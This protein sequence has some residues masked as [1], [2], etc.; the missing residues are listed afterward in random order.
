[1]IF[2]LISRLT[3]FTVGLLAI[4]LPAHG[5]DGGKINVRFVSFPKCADPKDME[6]VVGTEGK[7]MLVELPT[8]SISKTYTIDRPES[9]R[10]GKTDKNEEGKPI[11]NT[12]GQAP[13]IAP[14]EQLV[15]VL[16]KGATDED[17]L[18][19]VPMDGSL[20]GF[21]EASYL[22]YNFTSVKIAAKLGDKAFPVTAMSHEIVKPAPS[23]VKNG[24][25][26]IHVHFATPEKGEWELFHT[27]SWPYV[28]KS[29]TMVFFY[30]DPN[31]PNVLIHGITDYLP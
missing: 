28:K 11:F 26:L 5:Q 6:L 13:M 7:T 1:M 17:G 12:Y 23:E 20:E 9:W 30:A 21:G 16:R 2:S 10:L 3:F 15:L 22:V 29:R 4:L 19:L 25:E 8:N 24:R 14:S 27:S 31:S 18:K